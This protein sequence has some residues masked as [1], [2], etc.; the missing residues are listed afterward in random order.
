MLHGFCMD[1][2]FI[3]P[4]SHKITRK[5]GASCMAKYNHKQVALSEFSSIYPS[6]MPDCVN[7]PFSVLYKMIQLYIFFPLLCFPPL[8]SSPLTL[9][10]FPSIILST[11]FFLSSFL[12]LHLSFLLSFTCLVFCF[13]C[14]NLTLYFPTS[15]IL[16]PIFFPC[17]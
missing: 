4:V 13:K 2:H 7:L 3:L 1:L 14:L 12:H 6:L 9:I 11:S 5:S 10:P 16:L 15:S 17:I 8:P